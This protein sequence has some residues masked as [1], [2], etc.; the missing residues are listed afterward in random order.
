MAKAVEK[1]IQTM[2]KILESP[3]Y[4][5]ELQLGTTSYLHRGIHVNGKLIPH[6]S[7]QL[8]KRSITLLERVAANQKEDN[9]FTAKRRQYKKK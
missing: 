8:Q 5:Q 2:A 6:F 9:T 7:E 1:I 4:Q 3:E